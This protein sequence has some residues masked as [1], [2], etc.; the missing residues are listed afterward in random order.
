MSQYPLVV[1]AIGLESSISSIAVAGLRV[2]HHRSGVRG[3]SIS[4]RHWG[5][6]S[7]RHHWGSIRSRRVRRLR[8]HWGSI[9]S[10]RVWLRVAIAR[11]SEGS[12]RVT[13]V[14]RHVDWGP[15]EV[16]VKCFYRVRGKT[17]GEGSDVSTALARMHV[18]N[19]VSIPFVEVI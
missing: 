7:L 15:I 13:G 9:R 2:R 16:G 19:L 1:S 5:S 17:W 12:R 10:L 6:I 11:A 14:V 18:V 8:V 3:C 4:L